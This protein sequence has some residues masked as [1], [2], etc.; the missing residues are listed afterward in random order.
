MMMTAEQ[1]KR[2]NEYC[3]A[4]VT[5]WRRI[6]RARRRSKGKHEVATYAIIMRLFDGLRKPLRISMLKQRERERERE[7]EAF[8][9]KALPIYTAISGAK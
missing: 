8:K 9:Q 7:R 4:Y 2:R 5:L 3:Y 1:N 6:R